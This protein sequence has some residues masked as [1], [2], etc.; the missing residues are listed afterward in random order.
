MI[1]TPLPIFV[2]FRVLQQLAGIDLELVRADCA[3]TPKPL[4][5]FPVR[6]GRGPKQV[7]HPVQHDLEPRRTQQGCGLARVFRRMPAPIE[8]QD[9]VIH[10]LRAHLQL[11]HA[12]YAVPGQFFLRDQ[13][14]PG[15]NHQADVAVGRT[16][17]AGLRL[18]QG[19]KPGLVVLVDLV[20][21]VE[22]APH[23][24]LL[25]A[26]GIGTEAAAQDQE[27]D[28]IGG[29]P[30]GLQRPDPVAH[31][32]IRV[33][34]ILQPPPGAR[35]LAEVAFGHLVFLRAKDAVSGAGMVARQ[36]GNRGHP[37]EGAGRFH[38]DFP[39]QD[40]ILFPIAALNHLAIDRH[41]GV[42]GD[43]AAALR[44]GVC[45]LRRIQVHA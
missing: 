10:A 32:V 34:V 24:P 15:L 36:Y 23:E 31:L 42:F 38:A 41:Q 37:G 35:F 17:V 28:L 27:F 2:K 6:F 45:P 8:L 29:M 39:Q 13:V 21:R 7:G 20:H 14:R 11:G 22:A 33:E 25:V 1:I 3:L 16:R 18:R 44:F 12:Q 30:H 40:L 43:E 5:V 19:L 26:A 9:A 4:E